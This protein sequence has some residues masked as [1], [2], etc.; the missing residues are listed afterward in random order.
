MKRDSIEREGLG[1]LFV[2]TVDIN[3]DFHAGSPTLDVASAVR[4]TIGYSDSL[5]LPKRDLIL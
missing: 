3:V 1:R 5:L 2:R 4:V